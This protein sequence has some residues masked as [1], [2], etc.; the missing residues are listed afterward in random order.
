MLVDGL[1]GGTYLRGNDAG[2]RARMLRGADLEVGDIIM[3]YY[4]SNSNVANSVSSYM[5][6][7]TDDNSYH[8]FARFTKDEGIVLYSK[9]TSTLKSGYA[10]FKE[11]YSKDLFVVLRPFQIYGTTIK[12]DYNGGT[13]SSSSYTA[14]SNY[15]NLVKSPTKVNQTLSLVYNKT[16]DSSYKTSYTGI[17]TFDGW[18]SDKALTKRVTDTSSLASTSY[19][20]L[21]AKW[22][23]T[24]IK[25]P[26]PTVTGYNVEGWYSDKALTKKVANANTDYVISKTTTLY[27]KWQANSY[28]VKYDANGGTGTMSNSTHTYNSSANLRE[29]T[30][31]KT[32]YSFSGWSKTKTGSVSYKDKQSV[33]N[34]TTGTDTITLY[35]VWKQNEKYTVE[36]KVNNGTTSIS[37]TTIE[38]GKNVTITT[39]SNNG[40]GAGTVS[41]TN[42]QKATFNSGT[43]TISNINANTVCT[44]NYS[45]NKYD[46][47]YNTNGGTGTMSNSTHTYNVNKNLSKNIFVRDGYS[48]S[49]WA[50]ST[51][52]NVKYEDE[53]SVKNLTTGTNVVNLYAKWSANKYQIKYNANGG[54]GTMSNSTHTYDKVASLNTNTFKKDGYVFEG[55]SASSNGDVVYLDNQNVKNLTTG[56]DTITLYAVWRKIVS[57]DI[58]V[59][60]KVENGTSS[61]QTKVL[62][63]NQNVSFTLNPNTG[64][65][66][67]TV[68]CTNNQKATLT[69]NILTIDNVS[70]DTIC[71]VK[72]SVNKYS[73]R[74]NASGGIGTM[75]DSI[76][77]YNK[78]QSLSKNKFTKNGYTFIGWSLT[79]NGD[80][81][82]IDESKVKNLT[83]ETNVV[84]LY[85]VWKKVIYAINY[86]LDGGYIENELKNYDIETDNV[87]LVTPTKK[88][89]DFLGWTGSNGTNPHKNVTIQKGSYGTLN[90]KANWQ[91]ATY[92][93][94]YLSDK[95]G[96]IT[97]ITTEEVKYK[98]NPSGT[99]KTINSGYYEFKWAVNKD[100]LLNDGK[101]I[102]KKGAP[103]SVEQI[104]QISVEEDL[105]IT[106]YHYKTKYFVN[107][108]NGDNGSII[109]ITSEEVSANGSILGTEVKAKDGYVFAYWIANK[110]V[111]LSTGKIILANNKITND[112][113]KLIV[114]VDDLELKAEFVNINYN[115]IYQSD[116]NG[117]ISGI[118]KETKH[119]HQNPSGTSV[120]SNS[121]YVFAY[122]TANKDV[123]LND[124]TIIKKDNLITNDELLKIKIDNHLVFTAKNSRDT[125]KIFYKALDDIKIEG[126]E[127]EEVK[128]GSNPS[129]V[130]LVI[131]NKNKKIIWMAE[132]NV[133]LKDNTK[134]EAGKEITEEQVKEIVVKENLVLT[135]KYAKEE[136]ENL[137]KT[138]FN[139]FIIIGIFLILI[140]GFI[141]FFLKR[142]NKQK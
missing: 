44:V 32:G 35:A 21:Y 34:L 90:Y 141:M 89:Y 31:I 64:Y 126:N 137:V 133:I 6:L 47:K 79:N 16:V 5:Y 8:Y 113:V 23:A 81:D 22:K 92:T 130:K 82:F 85:A 67:G 71:T 115:L 124:G 11:F 12:Y 94:T 116:S 54:T 77:T 65:G 101:T 49:G 108:I 103:I 104:K 25:L 36:V 46:V 38:E 37:K 58:T 30:Y 106:A 72:Y 140:F 109:G 4:T 134:I 118:T 20:T 51:S 84:N 43:L 131:N 10:T 112:E 3:T 129:G 66:T 122:W 48:F 62:S 59:N 142:K 95:Y 127:I 76:H 42:N 18:Y 2:D 26:N 1:Y 80:F 60:V 41:C 87:M 98:G 111:K 52:G 91:E 93:I 7:G 17:N 119:Y 110:D 83:T 135:A 97:G 121:G 120:V 19:H 63:K 56:I 9:S 136:K 107:Y 40:Y 75:D 13:G 29:N 102:I 117:L 53:A 138:N 128:Y 28:Q 68:S 70:S 99:S 15:R 88:G 55:W 33:K 45:A 78:E 86:D 73:V 114:V 132:Q 27:A 61:P 69:A 50:Y 123:L 74:Y 105:V 14:Y 57:T 39:S 139:I 24:T 96:T 100:V 125:L